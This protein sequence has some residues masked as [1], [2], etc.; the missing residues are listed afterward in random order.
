M[1]SVTGLESEFFNKSWWFDSTDLPLGAVS[2]WTSRGNGLPIT[3][4]QNTVSLRPTAS[5]TGVT[6]SNHRLVNSLVTISPPYTLHFCGFF[7]SGAVFDSFTSGNYSVFYRDSLTYGFSSGDKVPL[8]VFSTNTVNP[9]VLTISVD[10]EGMG[11]LLFNSEKSFISQ[12]RAG[13]NPI[14]GI[15]LGA[16]NGI[17]RPTIN[18]PFV[19][20][21]NNFLILP[22]N[23]SFPELI[24]LHAWQYWR[25]GQASALELS[26]PYRFSA[27]KSQ[28]VA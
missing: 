26:H 16:F 11:N 2:S 23:L 9:D 20:T 13:R 8:S 25:L 10:S 17:A 3:L 12:G 19:G 22:Y 1:A 14:R 5:A 21:L 7:T 15:S 24:K 28:D 27:P 18:F 6:F 4:S